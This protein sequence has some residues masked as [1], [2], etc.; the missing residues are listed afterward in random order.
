MATGAGPCH[1]ASCRA[2]AARTKVALIQCQSIR[3]HLWQINSGE[4]AV[5]DRISLTAQYLFYDLGK[6]KIGAPVPFD[7]T[8][9][10]GIE[11]SGHL[12]TAGINF[13]F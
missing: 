1:F 12:I 4:W 10:Y 9:Y 5:S 11:N 8:Q 2:R 3:A 7:L 13:H 6:E